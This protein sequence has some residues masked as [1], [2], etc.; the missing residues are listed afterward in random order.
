MTST[1]TDMLHLQFEERLSTLY[2]RLVAKLNK[3]AMDRP[4]IRCT[5][6]IMGSHALCE[7]CGHVHAQES[8]AI[9]D[10]ATNHL[11]VLQMRSAIRPHHG[12][13]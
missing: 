1:S 2:R 6:S 10:Q 5:A 4:D 9:S 8:G 11:D 3:L 13:R 7:R 12:I